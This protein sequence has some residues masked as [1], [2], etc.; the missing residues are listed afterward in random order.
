M[1]I[2]HL[3]LTHSYPFLVR[4]N[5]F[6]Q[7]RW[8]NTIEHLVF[9]TLLFAFFVFKAIHMAIYSHICLLHSFMNVF[10]TACHCIY[11]F[12]STIRA[13]LPD[14]LFIPCMHF[15]YLLKGF[16][17]NYL[18]KT[19]FFVTSSKPFKRV[20]DVSNHVTISKSILPYKFNKT[21]FR[22]L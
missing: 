22:K 1:Y 6:L 8:L 15:C 11:C 7:Q 13:S 14:V 2:L 3:K 20:L 16:T 21:N 9:V 4:S 10:F 18:F 12:T 5:Q 19:K 17:T